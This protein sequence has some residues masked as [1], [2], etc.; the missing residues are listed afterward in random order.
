M[1]FFHDSLLQDAV[2]H[3][4]ACKFENAKEGDD[5]FGTFAPG[6]TAD[7]PDRPYERFSDY[8]ELLVRLMETDAE[9]YRT[10][11][12]GTPFG[13]LSW[14]A[15]DMGNYEKALFYLD[16]GI[17]EDVRKHKDAADPT[18]WLKNPGPRFLMLNVDRG[19]GFFA[20]TEDEVKKLLEQQLARFNKVSSKPALTLDSWR[21]FTEN[22]LVDQD[23]T[24]R[25]IISALYVFLL[26][27][28]DRE[29]ELSLRKGS[30][31][32][33]NQ[34]F[35]VHLLTGGLIF[36]SLLKRCYPKPLGKKY[37]TLGDILKMQAFTNDFGNS[38]SVC[39]SAESLADIHAAIK[40][41]SIETAFSTTGKL[42]NTTGHNLVW[43]DIFDTPRNYVDLFEQEMNAIFHVISQKL[44]GS[45]TSPAPAGPL[46]TATTKVTLA[47]VTTSTS[48]PGTEIGG[49]GT[50]GIL[51]PHLGMK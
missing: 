24:R 44:I 16:T 40:D 10:M 18:G 20:R 45:V 46:V 2:E 41:S 21:S 39:T 35:T 3:F 6:N 4:K 15:F 5:F 49:G 33:S 7:Y 48:G 9:K 32:G 47:T 1:Y 17:A 27:Y 37:Y 31:A 43:D 14:F 29:Q 42:R 8:E 19:H 36:E 51:P 34:P 22:L 26:E 30:T 38:C 50:S 13:F 11:H 23:P 12:K 25:S 28:R